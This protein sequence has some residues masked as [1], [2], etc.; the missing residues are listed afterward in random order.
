MGGR[1][2]K[3]R[4]FLL[5]LVLALPRPSPAATQNRFIVR[6]T[7]GLQALTQLC[8]LPTLGCTVVG[9]LD[10]S[11][12]QLF[13]LTT[14]STVD[15]N[16]FLALL[17]ATAGIVDAELDQVLSLVAGLNKVVTPYPSGLSDTTLVTYY[18]SSVWHGYVNQPAAAKVQVANAQNT[19]SVTGAGIVADID[20]GVDPNHPAFTGVLL[21]G[22]DFTRNQQGASEMNDLTPTD[23]PAFPPSA[24]SGSTCPQPAIVNQSS[25]AILDQSSAAIL[26]Q[27]V[28][29]AAFG[30]GTMVM[31]VIHLVAPNAKLLPL[32]AFHSDGT[33][34]L[35]DI[36]H[37]IYYAVQNQ[38]KANVINMSLDFTSY[39]TE[40]A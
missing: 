25:A 9:G 19:F 26:D 1:V 28:K 35:S 14:P 17:K 13:L 27:N 18:G 3:W 6:T 20:T 34:Y 40:L 5:S 12:N 22:Y 2:M 16:V 11:L 4:I 23:F 21:Q 36:L 38:P 30:H 10:G 8:A 39:S 31:G 24:C 33:G 15:P 32:K 7:L 29:Y 37:A